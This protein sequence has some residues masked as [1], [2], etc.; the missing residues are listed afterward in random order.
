MTKKNIELQRQTKD[1][2]QGCLMYL[3]QHYGKT[4]ALTSLTAGLPLKKNHI[5]P[6]MF[7]RAAKRAGLDA[8]VVERDAADISTHTLPAVVSL[9]SGRYAILKD[10]EEGFGKG[11]TNNRY[12]LIDTFTGEEEW[13]EGDDAFN[14]I[15]TGFTILTKPSIWHELARDTF[16]DSS[17]W[18]WSN[19]LPF[20][21]I[22]MQVALAAIFINLIA[23]ASP[24]FVMNVYD[25]VVPNLAYE[26]LWVLAIGII[27]VY[28]FDF[29]F[30]QLRAY[31]IDVA[32]KGADILLASRVY[33]QMMNAKLG[34]RETTSG[35]FANQV[36]EYDTL[37]DF[38]TS[39]TLTTLID[40]PF[41]LLFVAVIAMVGGPV[42]LVP[43]AAVPIV[44]FVC[45]FV[46]RPMRGLV[47]QVSQDMDAKHGHLIE[48]INGLENI[49]AIGSM[50]YAQGKW[51][52]YVGAGARLSAKT[53]FLAQLGINFSVF[54]QQL[55]TVFIVIW[56]VYRI[57]N[58]DMSMG[59]LVACSMLAGRALAPLGTAAGL[60]VRYQQAKSAMDG[61]NKLM[62][63]PVERPDG[64]TFV[65]VDDI[66][67]DV[68]FTDVTF[69]Y[70]GSN[71][72]CLNAVSLSIKAG[73]RVGIIG[74]AG[75]GK[76][77]LSR[78]LLNLYEPKSGNITLD[79][80]DI[81][82]LDP[83]VLRSF[84]SYAP[85]NLILFR[86]TLRQNLMLANPEATDDQLLQAAEIS[87]L[88]GFIRR[89]PMG[90]DL[91]VGERGESLSGGQRQAVGLA[92]AVLSQGKIAIFD[93]P[94]SEMDHASEEHVKTRLKKWLGDKSRTLILV[95]HRPAMLDLVDKLIVMHYGK[96]VAIG[97]K[98]KVLKSLETGAI[99]VRKG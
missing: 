79:G 66:K 92:R 23:L 68:D 83:A 88:M 78:L 46:Q 86:G 2:L 59:A 14:A 45:F 51:E 1:S 20:K 97:P 16:K 63:A 37:R 72:E 99:K 75:S 44:L 52:Q 80:L 35:A 90:F 30:K 89:H 34:T 24:L 41:I 43:L 10:K 81:R 26:T 4:H 11:G 67:G 6:Q 70:P 19:I 8:K 33:Q 48:T 71:M 94:T 77:T 39:T 76:S 95:T 9:T 17:E 62:E 47:Q 15:Y 74:R 12:A 87:G 96:M 64:H 54:A 40:L 29:T 91:P 49:K 5:T 55:V 69:A 31:F 60:Y 65:H 7:I 13:I 61:L 85:Q 38:F 84:I 36:K 98:D 82:Q 18:F 27:T 58:G 3:V 53:K 73:D 93:D 32:G 50:G 42:A 21:G 25:R 22:Y 56:G 28:I 57:G